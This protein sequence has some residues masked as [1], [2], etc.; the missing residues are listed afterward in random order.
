MKTIKRR[1]VLKG[2]AA[3][4]AGGA[5][6]ATLPADAQGAAVPF[7]VAQVFIPIAGSDQQFPVRLP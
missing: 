5:A 3:M 4:V 2:A 6:T 7:T 1:D